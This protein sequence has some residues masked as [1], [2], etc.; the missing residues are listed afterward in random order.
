MFGYMMLLVKIPAE[1][2]FY[3][4]SSAERVGGK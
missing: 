3:W 1:T 4:R 2:E